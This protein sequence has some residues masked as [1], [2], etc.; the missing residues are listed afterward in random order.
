MWEEESCASSKSG[1]LLAGRAAEPGAEFLAERQ[2]RAPAPTQPEE[3]TSVLRSNKE[4][5]SG[6]KSSRS[7]SSEKQDHTQVRR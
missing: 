1:K 2:R 4:G 7:R 3:A 6:E 5:D